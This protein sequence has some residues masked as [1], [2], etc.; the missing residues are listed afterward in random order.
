MSN[1]IQLSRQENAVGPLDPDTVVT[2]AVNDIL[3]SHAEL[4]RTIKALSEHLDALDYLTETLSNSDKRA[5]LK[6]QAKRS[7]DSLSNA[8]LDLS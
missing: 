6:Q 5:W 8:V 7:R 1:V 3:A 2:F 4:T